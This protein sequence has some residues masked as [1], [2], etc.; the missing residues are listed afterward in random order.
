VLGAVMEKAG[1]NELPSLVKELLLRPLGMTDTM[2]AV[3][4]RPRLAWPYAEDKA[5]KGPPIRM[6]EP[7]DMKDDRK[8]VRFSP[9]RIFDSGS[10]PSGGAGLAGTA[11][12]YLIFLEAVRTGGAGVLSPA[13]VQA[14][15][16]DQL[17]AIKGLGS[18]FGFTYG[19]GV[20]TDPVARKTVRGKG[21]LGWGGIYGTGFW[22]DPVAKLSVV[23]LT[24]VAGDT[25]FDR[26]VEQAIY[27]K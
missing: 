16:T 22:I 11:R 24:N 23:M 9:A 27:A 18:G 14:M 20:V 13:T 8:V 12:D 17:G 15:S 7:Y 1:G 3:T 6:T 19:F 25:P 10:F 21:T 26:W 4:D 5:T 2:F